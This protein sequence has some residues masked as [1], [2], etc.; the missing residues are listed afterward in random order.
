MT[1]VDRYYT[2]LT[3]PTMAPN[4][5]AM[6]IKMCS[7]ALSFE[8][9]LPASILIYPPRPLAVIELKIPTDEQADIWQA[10]NQLQTYKIR[11]DITFFELKLGL[12][13]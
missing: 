4:P 13:T 8:R 1:L 2:A 6:I 5:C 11:D 7:C 10:F 9:P 3:L 12:K